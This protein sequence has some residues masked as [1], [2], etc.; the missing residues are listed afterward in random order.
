MHTCTWSYMNIRT[1]VI[2]AFIMGFLP[3][4]LEPGDKAI[5]HIPT[6]EPVNKTVT[7][8]CC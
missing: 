8:A 3:Y 1:Y 5:I 7:R 2:V 6:R 4:I